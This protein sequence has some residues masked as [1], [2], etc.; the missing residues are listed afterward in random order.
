LLVETS[1]ISADTKN[2]VNAHSRGLY[3]FIWCQKVVE[4]LYKRMK[5]VLSHVFYVLIL[6]KLNYIAAGGTATSHDMKKLLLLATAIV[7]SINVFADNG[8]TCSITQGNTVIGYV[9]AWVDDNGNLQVSN[10]T[11]RR[12]TVTVDLRNGIDP[13]DKVVVTINP[14]KTVTGKYGLNKTDYV[15]RVF[16]PICQ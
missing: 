11:D 6:K 14:G 12:V 15:E 16:N 13:E 5:K 4:D 2:E 7:F 8:K 10:D 3:S 1:T 9:T